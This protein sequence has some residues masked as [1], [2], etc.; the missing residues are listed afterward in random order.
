MFPFL[1]EVS[2]QRHFQTAFIQISL[3]A[4]NTS[5]VVAEEENNGIVIE[6]FIF[7]VLQEEAQPS[8]Y[9]LHCLKMSGIVGTYFRQ[10]GYVRRQ[11]KQL[12]IDTFFS[13]I[14]SSVGMESTY[15]SH[16]RCHGI[17]H[18]EERLVFASFRTV[19]RCCLGALVPASL[20]IVGRVIM[21]LA[22]IS[23]I[24]TCFAQ[25]LR[26]ENIRRS[27]VRYRMNIHSVCGCIT[28]GNK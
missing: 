27:I 18:S 9:V 3:T 14:S 13:I 6:S 19:V 20:V 10:I 8:I 4:R 26:E 1:W 22:I 5:S 23:T 2:N 24:I 15:T 25:S 7:Q 12:R 28:T 11:C 16:V 21:R 17:E